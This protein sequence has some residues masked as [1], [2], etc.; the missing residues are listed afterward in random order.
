MRKSI[1]VAG[2]TALI[3]GVLATTALAQ[4]PTFSLKAVRVNPECVGGAN[5]GELCTKD[6]DCDSVECSGVIPATNQIDADPGDIIVTEIYA[7]DW[8][9]NAERLTVFQVTMD[10]AG[11][12]SGAT[13]TVLPPSPQRICPFPPCY[14]DDDCPY[15]Y[16]CN[17]SDGCCYRQGVFIDLSRTD[18]VFLDL[19]QFPAVDF[20]QYRISSLLF[21]P[22]DGPVYAP[23][24]KYC[25]TLILSVSDDA[26]GVFTIDADTSTEYETHM[27]DS[28][29]EF[30]LPLE[31]EPLI[32]DVPGCCVYP[33]FVATN[34]PNCAIDA[35]QPS[36][37]DG[38]NRAGWDSI[39]ITFADCDTSNLGSEDFSVRG[40]PWCDPAP[41]MVHVIPN[42]NRATL[43]LSRHVTLGGWICVT[44]VVTGEEVCLAHLPGDVNNDGTSAPMDILYLIDC[45]NGLRLC[46]I[47]QCDVDRSGMCGPPDIL[48]VIDLLNG[49]AVY[50]EWRD[51]SLPE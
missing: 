24:P 17:P 1:L 43:L 51:R 41:C 7:S 44:Y 27:L 46:E 26:C 36:D 4:M 22:N 40:F 11:F 39:E 3:A 48:R 32:I 6:E 18:Y 29:R 30:I 14:S 12:R 34:P 20:T 9:P 28:A 37:P 50:D 10:Q 13:G 49:A 25:G 8:S 23:P 16:R 21:S 31:T 38:S 15:Y 45:L 42:G 2:L 19:G 33:Q 35:R 47:W 5:A